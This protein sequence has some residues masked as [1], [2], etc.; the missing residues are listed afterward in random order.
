MKTCFKSKAFS[1]M[2]ALV[3]VLSASAVPVIAAEGEYSVPVELTVES[4]IFE[5]TVPYFL[6]ITITDT[7]EV[8]T[9]DAAT[10]IN[11]SAGPIVISD[12]QT[13]GI[14]GWKTV[15]YGSTSTKVNAKE[16]AMQLIFDDGET[17]TTVSTTGNDTNDFTNPI[18]IAK[19]Q[20]L[21]MPYRAEV[22]AQ[23]S[24][25]ES[26]QVV[27]VAFIFDWDE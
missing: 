5:V 17:T 12:I 4:P 10:I 20:T 15:A 13:K 14:N 16:V 27:E 9:S 7:G 24:I 26:I 19:G 3:M 1:I 25:Y 11:H 23:S 2:L 8:V 22:P 18:R 6:P 21:A